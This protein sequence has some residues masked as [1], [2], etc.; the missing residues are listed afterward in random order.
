MPRRYRTWVIIAASAFLTAAA[1]SACGGDDGDENARTGKTEQAEKAFL[2]GMVAHHQSAIEMADI[3]AQKGQDAF[4]KKLARDIRSTQDRE[5]VRMEEIYERR[6]GAELK[7]DSRAHDALGLTAEEAGMTHSPE[8]SEMLRAANP[9]D[10]AFVDE[11]VPHH[12]GAIRMANAVLKSTKDSGLRRL[13][14]GIV[15][16]QEREIEEMNDFR[17]REFGGPVPAGAGHKTDAEPKTPAG[18]EEHGAGHS[19]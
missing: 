3:A 19:E 12:E 4:I 9:F 15:S 11:M 10:R 1:L 16:T 5:I 17:T 7:P 6:F 18:D 2:T 13:A 8:T 14:E